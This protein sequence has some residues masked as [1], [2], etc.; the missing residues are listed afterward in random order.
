M[1]GI[2]LSGREARWALFSIPVVL[3]GITVFVVILNMLHL[4]SCPVTTEGMK[5]AT[6]NR[7]QMEKRLLELEQEML[8]N[9]ILLE[10][11]L[12]G[13]DQKFSASQ[14][15]QLNKL[16]DDSHRVAQRLA[17]QLASDSPPPLTYATMAHTQELAFLWR[18]KFWGEQKPPEPPPVE[19]PQVGQK[20]FW[21][22]YDEAEF[23]QQ[24]GE[25]GQDGGAGR[26]FAGAWIGDEGSYGEGEWKDPYANEA[27]NEFAGMSFNELQA[28]CTGWLTS[29]KVEPGSSWG[30]LPLDLQNKWLAANCDYYV[31]GLAQ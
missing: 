19:P 14:H 29:Y 22:S 2:R 24:Q 13:L 12:R 7:A 5:E 17:Q 16:Q 15:V 10:G 9:S 18:N 1:R 20:N 21:D 11:F 30:T 27:P 26:E 6:L 8:E 28:L 23:F 31:G 3:I 4:H 25:G